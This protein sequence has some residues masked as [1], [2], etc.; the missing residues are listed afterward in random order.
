MKICVLGTGYVGLVS[1]VC[2]AE[3]GHQVVG[4]DIDEEKIKKLKNGISPIYE[5]GLDDLLKKNLANGNLSFTNDLSFGL[6]DA[7]VVLNAVGTPP[8]EQRRVDLRYVYEVAKQVGELLD[9]YIV[10]VNKSTVPVGTADE[11]KKIIQKNL[12]NEVSF[13]VASNPEFLREGSA[14][15][16]FMKP[17]RIIIGVESE[18]AEEYLRELYKPFIDKSDNF[19]TTSIKSAE[20]IKYASNSF[21]ATK[22]SFI[23][24][25]ANLCG[26]VGAD[27]VEVSKGMGLDTRIN[28][29]FLEAGPG[30]GGSCFPKD[31]DEFIHTASDNGVEMRILEAVV[32]TN[33]FQ[34][35]VVIQKLLKHL[36]DLTGKTIAIWGLSFKPDT[37]DCRESQSIDIIQKL[38]QKGA[39]VKCFDPMGMENTKKILKDN[40]N[41]VEFAP[42][43]MSALIDSD[44]LILMTHWNEFKQIDPMDIK[45]YL[46]IVIDTRNLW[47][48]KDFEKQGLIYEGM[49]R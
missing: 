3:L 20:L 44:A 6:K 33:Q 22:I 47:P 37:D 48:R 40:R 31:V 45:K 15:L 43:K 14:V 21:L 23:N 30:F 39:R 10:F 12:K 49:G 16:D 29:K 13:D 35:S 5:I 42:D 7:S 18:K 19:M 9:H 8:D 11:V 24:E 38:I 25:V 26:I 17:D 46:S 1:S 27:V 41:Y 34:R 28:N 4:V 2:F 36:P 32:K